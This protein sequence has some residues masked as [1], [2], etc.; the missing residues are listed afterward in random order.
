MSHSASC[1]AASTGDL[2][3]SCEDCKDKKVGDLDDKSFSRLMGITRKQFEDFCQGTYQQ[4][5]PA[6]VL[7]R[8]STV[9][10]LVV[11]YLLYNFWYAIMGANALSVQ[12]R[13]KEL[14]R[15]IASK[16]HV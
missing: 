13:R 5:H 6:I 16:G 1:S 2:D 14:E 12:Y 4:D 7:P 15:R 3:P 9:Q 11:P 8:G 10:T